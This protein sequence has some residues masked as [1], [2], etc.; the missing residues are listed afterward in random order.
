VRTKHFSFEE[1]SQSFDG[2][3][4]RVRRSFLY[5][6]FWMPELLVRVEDLDLTL[7]ASIRK[8]LTKADPGV[9]E[10]HIVT[11]SE[12]LYSWFSKLYGT[13][14]F[15]IGAHFDTNSR[16]I[17]PLRWQLLIGLLTENKLDFKSILKMI[18]S[19]E[20]LKFLFNRRE[21]I[22]AVMLGF[23]FQVGARK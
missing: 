21:E 12:A 1:L 4:R 7:S 20:G 13:D 14:G 22:I 17:F 15:W 23:N 6:T 8:G 18:F 10:H 2:Y 16:K 11:T 9:A 19:A 3:S 5:S